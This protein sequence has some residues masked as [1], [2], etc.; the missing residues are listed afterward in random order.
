MG[1]I[2]IGIDEAGFFRDRL[3]TILS[4]LKARIAGIYGEDINLDPETFDGQ[5]VGVYAEGA[6]DL[7]QAIEDTYNGRNP[8]TATGQNLTS[9]CRLN[10][11]N[12]E[13]GAFSYVNESMVIASGATVPTGTKVQDEDTG[14]I[15]ETQAPAVGTGAAQL[16]TCKALVKGSYSASGK[17]T[18]IVNPTYGLLSVTNPEPSSTVSPEESDERLR[19]RR[20]QST[21]APTA[22][23]L[24]SIYAG[25][26]A[27]PGIGKL[28]VRE[29]DTGTYADIKAGDQALAPHSIAVVVTAG[30]ASDIGAAI[31]A[32]KPPGVMSVG[33]SEVVVSDSLGVPHTMRYTV[34][35]E[36][37]IYIRIT[38]RERPGAGFGSEGGEAAIKT[39]L[40]AWFDE[41]Q[42][43]SDDV[44]K[45]WVEAIAQNT[46]T[47]LDGLPAIIVEDVELGLTEG[48]LASANLGLAWNEIAIL[49]EEKIL[50]E[51]VA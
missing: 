28:R 2:S 36:V 14:S 40:L 27:T 24:D 22:G 38:Y 5:L 21:A 26:G 37:E 51:K 49:V 44:Y 7:G 50:M 32:R 11:V 47:G 42:L 20:N 4:K 3:A 43:P 41:K 30:S 45:G 12:R 48:T 13:V 17:V 19:I 35:T 9:T 33:T 23:Y 34:A 29:N 16:V 31:Y 25:V 15:Y 8:D 18:K 1:L 39:A 46:V 10:G 6:D